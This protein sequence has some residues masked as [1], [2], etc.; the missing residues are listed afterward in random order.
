MKKSITRTAAVAALAL[1]AMGATAMAQAATLYSAG[2]TVAMASPGSVSASFNALAG[3]G[4][5]SLQLRGYDTLD[6]DNNWIDILHITLNGS[7]VFA[8]TWDLGGGGIDRVLANP[9]GGTA[10]KDMA[11]HTV[12]INLPLT[13]QG[14]S[15]ALVIS[16]ESPNEFEGIS[17][18]GFQGLGDEGW[19][20]NSVQVTGAVPEPATAVLML[21]GVGLLAGAVARRRRA[22]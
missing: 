22:G 21:A 2:P 3:A 20:Y 14:G 11:T 1:A 16:Y 19:G 12:A 5:L 17:R 8:G 7:E 13:L 10:V 4:S 6:G 15:N 18:T 9:N